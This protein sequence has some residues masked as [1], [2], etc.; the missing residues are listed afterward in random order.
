[1]RIARNSGIPPRQ[2][3]ATWQLRE[4]L[5]LAALDELE[6]VGQAKRLAARICAE[7]NNS[8]RLYGWAVHGDA[9]SAA[10]PLRD[11]SLWLPKRRPAKQQTA[12]KLTRAQRLNQQLDSAL[13]SLF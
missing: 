3:E 13:S 12:P 2:I 1:L 7:I 4:L 9:K 8:I 6:G 10:P 5:D 11:E